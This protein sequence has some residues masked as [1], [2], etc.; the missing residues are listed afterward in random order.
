[1]AVAEPRS[2]GYRSDG[3]L[4][5]CWLSDIG[6]LRE[7]N[8]D[9]CLVMPE[10]GL[11]A[12][13]DGMGGE[14]AGEVAAGLVVEWLPDLIE[15]HVGGVEPDDV[16]QLERALRDAIVVLNHRMRVECSSLS[17]VSKMGATVAMA[18]ARRPRVHVAHMGDSR[19]CAFRAGNL[20]QLTRDHSVV[21]ML[22]E[23]G[24]ITEEQAQYHP[25]KGNLAR[26]VG[27]GGEARPDVTT[28]ELGP[29]ERLLLCTDGLPDAVPDER[30]QGLLAERA[31]LADACRALIET[32]RAA[33]ARDNLTVVLAEWTAP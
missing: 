1:M 23:S 13:A 10:K 8:Q 28:I 24:A 31:D 21:G 30:V 16:R 19:V 5:V 33:G 15:E 11:L 20:E 26:Y 12:V 9:A 2:G 25:M 29:G 17:G 7:S 27:M 3:G 32:G 22:V 6:C 14:H 18:L 4:D